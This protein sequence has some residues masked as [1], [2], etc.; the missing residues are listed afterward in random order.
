[1]LKRLIPILLALTVLLTAC[2]QEAPPTMSA[3]DV[4]GTAVSAAWTV[5]AMTQQAIPTNT[6]VPPTETP[7]PTLPPTFTLP[8]PPTSSVPT[9]DPFAVAPTS[10]TSSNPCYKPLNVGEAGPRKRVRIENKSGGKITTISLNLWTPNAHGQCGALAYYNILNNATQ[11]VELPYGN[12]YAY[13]WIEYKGGTTS[14]SEG[15]FVVPLA[16][17]DLFS[18]VVGKESINFKGP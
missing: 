15:S 4:Q 10:T 2:G 1:M 9:L 7:S 17:D 12:W 8:A 5:V 3:A 18:L 13:A 16:G 6:P 14:N 11:I